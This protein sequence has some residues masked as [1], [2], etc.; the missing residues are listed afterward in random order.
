MIKTYFLIAWRNVQKSKIYSA[1]N[2]IGLSTGMAVALLIGLWIWDE[3]SYDDY[4]KNKE[5]LARI[6]ATQT[7]NGETGS[8]PTT[9][10]PLENELR[11][12][13]GSDIKRLSLISYNTNIL[14]VGAKR[15]SASGMWAG[16][17]ITE[18]LTLSM[19]RGSGESFRDPSTILISTS[20]AKTLFADSDPI[21]QIVKLDNRGE[22]KIGGVYEDLPKNTSFFGTSYLLPWFNKQNWWNTQTDA[23]SNHGCELMVE[24]NE[25]TDIEK[26]NAKIKMITQEHGYVQSNELLMLHPMDSWHLYSKF[27]NGQQAGG[28]IQYV[29]LFGTIGF[30][31]LLLACINFMNLSTA[32]SEKRAKEVGIRKTI[33]SGRLEL[34]IQ[35]LSE[36]MVMSFFATV[37]AVVLVSSTLPFFNRLSDKVMTMPWSNP[38]FWLITIAFTCIVSLVAGSYPAFYLSSFQP[39]KVLKGTM[40]AGRFSAI[41][42]KV[43]VVLQ[44][45]VSI[46][47]IIGTVVVYRQVQFAKSRP[48]GYDRDHLI[49]IK[50]NTPEIYAHYDALRADLIASGGA[51]EM[52]E[53]NS[54]TTQ[55]WSNNSG[56]DWEGRPADLDPLF[57]TIAV[58]H[59]FGKTIGWKIVEGRDF[60]RSFNDTGALILN[61][62]ALKITGIKNPVGKKFRLVNKT[63]V[64]VGIV[65]DMVMSSP[66]E[67]VVPT[68]FHLQP[69]WVKLVTV[70][71]NPGMNMQFALAKI[72]SV[73]KKY[74]PASPFEYQFIDQEYGKKFSEEE[75]VG[76]L[77]TI[78]AVLAIFISCL[79]L[80]GLAS[81]V[82]EQ[83]TREIGVRKVL[84]A[85]VFIL[86]K[87]L[88]KEFVLLVT[89][90][91]LIAVP[92]ATYFLRG[93]LNNYNYRTEISWWIFAI[94]ILGALMITIVTISF[95]AIRAALAN[96]VKSLR[97]Q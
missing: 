95:Q 41:P 68:I 66:F 11:T 17:D 54:A 5:R 79:G 9:V 30:F 75:R 93:W 81:F 55:I 31:V 46:V 88:S 22:L 29:I 50:M 48:V 4:F 86:W 44:F 49:T 47:L 96:P 65:K 13:Y 20:M 7:F 18:M 23:W 3:V 83:R 91:C 24:L 85:S 14:A 27:E 70:K 77:T 69:G 1:I 74:N 51:I 19:I 60:S 52:A 15:I 16:P 36:S 32:R 38:A 57:G 39:I 72:E 21:G 43:L 37:V 90:S 97:M 26:T 71:I 42:R 56:M 45:T 33:G 80:Y 10:V 61:E 53:S 94:A 76:N 59:D 87:L 64:I 12:K 78:F 62:A 8:Y 40:V 35:F 92:V 82:A 63:E 28:R 25:N 73:F 84:G 34:V 89:I 58:T 2:I 67:P 6:I